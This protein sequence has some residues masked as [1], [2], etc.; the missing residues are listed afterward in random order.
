MTF[1]RKIVVTGDKSAKQAANLIN[2][3]RRQAQAWLRR[4]K[5]QKKQSETVKK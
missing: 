4:N 1:S 5:D 2:E 3:R